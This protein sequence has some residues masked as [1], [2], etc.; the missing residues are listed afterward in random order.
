MLQLANWA[1]TH[2][3]SEPWR[4]HIFEGEALAKLIDQL[5]DIYVRETPTDKFEHIKIDKWESR[6]RQVSHIMVI[7][8][9]RHEHLDLPEFEEIASVAMAV[10]NMWIYASTQEGVGGY[11]S[12]PEMVFSQSFHQYLDLEQDERC[13]GLFML[14]KIKGDAIEAAAKRAP[15]EEKVTWHKN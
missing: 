13:L 4:F 1:P 11:W 15:W 3:H 9:K 10:Q 5:K 7:V 6:K 12:T 2:K 14:G 8:L